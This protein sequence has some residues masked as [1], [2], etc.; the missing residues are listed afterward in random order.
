MENNII[1]Q[2]D[3]YKQSHHA[4]YPQG[5]TGVYS[6]F[7]S[8]KGAKW[9]TTVFNGLQTLMKK[10][11]VGQVVTKAK[12]DEAQELVDAHFMNPTIFNRPMWEHILNK[13]DGYLPITIRAVPEGTPVSVSNVLMTVVN[14][15]P[16]CAPLTN[17]LETLLTHVWFPSTVATLS[18]ETKKVMKEYLEKTAMTNDALA[19]QLHDFGFRGT[20]CTESAGFGGMGHLLNFYGTDTIEAM[21]YAK[22]YYNADLATLAF[23]VPATEHSVATARGPQGE[24]D[25]VQQMLDTYPVGIISNVADSY[26]IENFVKTI[27]SK[28]FKDQIMARNHDEIPCKFVVR[29]DSVRSP[30]DTPHDQM[31]W[32][33]NQ[34]WEDFG[35]TINDKGFK[36]LDSHVGLLWGDGIDLEG[37]TL[38]LEALTKAG[39]STENAVFGM[40]GGLLQKV[41]RDTQ[42]FAFKCSA[43]QRNDKW[44]DIYKKP[45]DVSK[46]SKKGMLRLVKNKKGEFE[47]LPNLG[48]LDDE[49]VEVFRN[50]KIVKEYTFDELR[51]NAEIK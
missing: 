31:V 50:G 47:T 42:R 7:E 32:I 46:A 2:T 38:I 23:S 12:I 9:D 43:Q 24:F 30:E 26:D 11:L 22:E 41:N 51:Q 28:R 44:I 4:E 1:L 3:S 25:V 40:G 27:G 21:R 8:R 20:E 6:Y 16:M 29:P 49:M 36:V 14:T 19:F 34:L 13:Y 37:I 5:T 15:D 45:K 17:H 10:Y 39:Y 18:R 35:G 33:A 48:E